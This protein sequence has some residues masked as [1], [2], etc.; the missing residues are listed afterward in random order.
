[1][2][3]APPTQRRVTL[4]MVAASAGVS[5]ATVSKVLNGRND[6]AATTRALV[7]EALQRHDYTASAPQRSAAEAIR[8]SRSRSTARS[9]RTRL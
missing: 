3:G 5:I 4:A 7:Q 9:A 1:M 6:V 2:D 8:R